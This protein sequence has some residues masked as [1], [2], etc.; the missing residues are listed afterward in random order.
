M[1]D[2][3]KCA[4]IAGVFGVFWSIPN[5]LLPYFL[6]FFRPQLEL[7]CAH[8]TPHTFPLA[9]ANAPACRVLFSLFSLTLHVSIQEQ[10][11][12]LVD[13]VDFRRAVCWPLPSA[14]TS[15]SLIVQTQTVAY[16]CAHLSGCRTTFTHNF[17]PRMH[18]AL[19]HLITPSHAN[20]VNK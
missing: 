19:E 5:S 15:R 6:D 4:R 20:G 18:R 2:G 9:N 11:P 3:M 10:S 16:V 7:R 8:T 13:A 17:Q 14:R 1:Q 12:L